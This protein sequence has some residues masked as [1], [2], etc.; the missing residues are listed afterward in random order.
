VILVDEASI[1]NILLELKEGLQRLEGKFDSLEGKVDK[2]ESK[3]DRLEGKVDKLEGKVDRLEGK[4]D[5]LEGKVDRLEASQAEMRVDIQR[6]H[7]ELKSQSDS[8][9]RVL[10]FASDTEAVNEKRYKEIIKKIDSIQR[11]VSVNSF[12]IADLKSMAQ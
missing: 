3:V 8:I 6:I 11:V 2:L 5:R 7:S 10:N 12:D 4:V 9:G 1:M